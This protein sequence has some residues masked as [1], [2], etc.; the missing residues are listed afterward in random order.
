MTQ[1]Q[2]PME[3]Y[4]ASL[5]SVPVTVETSPPRIE[6]AEVWP[7]PDLQRIWARVQVGRFAEF[8]DLSFRVIDPNGETACTLYMVE[9]REMYQS[10]T[11]HLRREPQP[12]AAYRL[13]IE[14]IRGDEQLDARNLD[15]NLTY[16]E[17]HAQ[18]PA[19]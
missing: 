12:D 13:Q 4:R 6:R 17:P 15:F 19:R 5:A 10:I 18:N 2:D 9:I 3:I 16:T 11:L 1:M 7:Y 8:P 14:L